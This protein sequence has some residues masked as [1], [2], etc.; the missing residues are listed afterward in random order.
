MT[1]SCQGT[2][3]AFATQ[4]YGL[5]IEFQANHKTSPQFDD[6]TSG[7]MPEVTSWC[8]YDADPPPPFSPEVFAAAQVHGG[9]LSRQLSFWTNF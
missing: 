1:S 5:P 4:L 3:L 6:F 9:R 8:Q 7:V 2:S